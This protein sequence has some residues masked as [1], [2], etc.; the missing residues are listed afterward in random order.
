LA[1]AA[2]ADEIVF[3]TRQDF[4]T[5]VKRLTQDRGVDVVYDS[6]GQTTFLKGLNCL[7]PRGMMALF[8]Q[9][10]GGVTPFDPALLAAKGSLFLTRPSLAQYAT[11]REELLWRAGDVLGWIQSGALK[12]RI[13]RTYR[14]AEAPQAHRDLEGRKTSGKILLLPS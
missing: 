3:Y 4:E 5:E 2:G 9:S 12:I 7:R 10:S 11:H 1:K 14:L 13:E 6:V 8:G